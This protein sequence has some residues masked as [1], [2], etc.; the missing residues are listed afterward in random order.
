MYHSQVNRA[1]KYPSYNEDEESST[2]NREEGC[3][4][5]KNL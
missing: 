2:L 3:P 5:Y 1:Q 4:L